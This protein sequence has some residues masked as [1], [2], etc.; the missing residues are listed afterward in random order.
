ME[1]WQSIIKTFTKSKLSATAFCKQYGIKR[2]TF[3]S[4]TISYRNPSKNLNSD[5]RKQL[6]LTESLKIIN[7][8][9]RWMTEENQS[10]LPKSKIGI[11]FQYALARW[12]ELSAYLNDGAIEMTGRRYATILS[13][14]PYVQ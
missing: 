13:R 4:A 12:D 2:P 3:Y 11:A 9:G 6:R 10:I 14:M 1:N 7:A 8:L 5:D